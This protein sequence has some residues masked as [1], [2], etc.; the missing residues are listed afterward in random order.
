MGSLRALQDRIRNT[1]WR[2]QWIPW[3]EPGKLETVYNTRL[4]LLTGFGGI[5]IFIGA[6]VFMV[7]RS[8]KM[9]EIP[10]RELIAPI[11]IAVSGWIIALLGR[12]YAAKHKQAGWRQVTAQ[13]IDQEIQGDDEGW[14]YRL[15]CKI[16][17]EGREY[18]VTPEPSH[19]IAFSSK[20]AAH[21]YLASHIS[22]EAECQLLIDPKN[23]LHAVFHK[24]QII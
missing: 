19:S 8:S 24:K 2:I 9:G 4:T 23:P 3:Q 17:F 15:L 6:I 20:L 18:T 7:Y 1:G 16:T 14:A 11:S 21:R 5:A 22:S 10:P 12:F 13:V